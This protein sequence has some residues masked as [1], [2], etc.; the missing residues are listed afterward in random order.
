M[1]FQA[2]SAALE[3]QDAGVVDGAI[4]LTGGIA[5]QF[6]ELLNAA[7][8]VATTLLQQHA[9]L[10][11]SPRTL[12]ADQRAAWDRTANVVRARSIAQHTIS[13][14]SAPL[15]P[16]TTAVGFATV[17]AQPLSGT[18]SFSGQSCSGIADGLVS[19]GV[20]TDSS[21]EGAEAQTPLVQLSA[22]NDGVMTEVDYGTAL[23]ATGF[24]TRV[25]GT[26]D[27]SAIAPA[28]VQLF[29]SP[30]SNTPNSAYLAFVNGVALL[31]ATTVRSA[32]ESPVVLGTSP[33]RSN[34]LVVAQL[35]RDIEVVLPAALDLTEQQPPPDNCEPTYMV[36]V[37][38]TSD[39]THDT[40][41]TVA[42]FGVIDGLSE[43]VLS[44]GGAAVT[45]ALL[46]D[47]VWGILSTYAPT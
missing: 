11:S 1:S 45:L 24:A 40:T 47:G 25:L 18:L 13:P 12:D 30:A 6:I 41:I 20:V 19:I 3:I 39:N 35:S 22:P 28:V 46:S 33:Y 17:T 5:G 34:L 4:T 16:E 43:Y 15:T 23:T 21:K 14:P 29:V 2:A 26:A 9:Y 8:D 7:P 38:L 37:K 44:G 42:K 32:S 27:P 31:S 36:T 10:R